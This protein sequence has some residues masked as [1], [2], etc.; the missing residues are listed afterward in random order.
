M[1][2]PCN[3][4]VSLHASLF[5]ALFGLC[6]SANA[7]D[8]EIH[9]D[10]QNTGKAISPLLFGH[11]IEVTRRGIWSGLSAEMVAN[12]KFAAI[13]GNIPA[14]WQVIGTE[15]QVSIDDAVSYAGR[16][17]VRID[18]KMEGSETGIMQ[19][20]PFLS[21]CKDTRYVVRV[22]LKTKTERKVQVQLIGANNKQPFF[23]KKQS[24]IP[25]DWQLLD[26]EFISPINEENNKLEIT[27]DTE[28]AFWVGAVSV[29]P[30]DTLYGMRWDVIEQLKAIK[31]GCLRYPGGCYAEFYEWQEGLLPLDQRSPIY[32]T[33][34]D[35]L[36]RNTDDTDTH[37]VGIDEFIA[38][39]REVGC[40]PAITVRLSENI[41]E[42]AFALVEYCNGKADTK[43]GKIR[44]KRGHL[45]PYN[46]RY[47]FVGNEIWAFGRGNARGAE[48]CAEQ[49][50][51]FAQAMKEADNNIKLIACTVFDFEDAK[52]DWNKP[53]LTSLGDLVNACS[54]HKYILDQ[55]PLKTDEDITIIAKAPTQ[56]IRQMLQTARNFIEKEK[57]VGSRIGITFD[58]WNTLWGNSG[59]IAMG[60]YTASKLN[61]LVR[62]AE[63]L[64][65]D[66]ACYFMPINE[67]AI[68]TTPITAELDSAGYIFDLF[69]LHQGNKLLRIP[70][71]DGDSDID[72]CAS[73][74]SDSK[75]IYVTLVNRNI[76]TEYNVT[77]SFDNLA[78][79][80]SL[81]A[82]VDFLIPNTLKIEESVFQQRAE[83]L[84]I[85]EG[86]RI[87]VT[88]PPGSIVGV[89]IA[90]GL[91]S[92]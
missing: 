21:F 17:S 28:G 30:T 55:L 49:S 89:T 68:K 33:G 92:F 74:T 86:H 51:L 3:N 79:A 50:R 31:P 59:S 10:A 69:K 84:T 66:M 77:I 56:N 60:L 80:K 12:R 36:F 91:D 24:L 76:N 62:E 15:D 1:I 43:W 34:L 45:D 18:V 13:A 35:F 64:G 2:C 27:S 65:I 52:S 11:N 23:H 75:N 70:E 19:Q 82:T 88:I 26:G 40:E 4:M 38:L 37:E 63:S 44:T 58:E 72:A 20:Q 6:I 9:I 71:T 22:W 5:V 39:C 67:G 78:V 48:G 46:V 87:K 42:N 54:A 57:P 85:V 8:V 29:K 47:W 32:H 83:K 53:L 73:V 25:G 61:M 7:G 14:R 81:T 41:P 16:Q 90:M